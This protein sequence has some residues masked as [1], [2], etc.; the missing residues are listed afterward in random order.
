MKAV[1]LLCFVAAAIADPYYYTHN[2][3]YSSIYH[4]TTFSSHVYSPYSSI[5][6]HLYKRE[7]EAE[8]EAAHHVMPWWSHQK[9]N[10]FTPY[11]SSSI[12]YPHT[13][14]YSHLYK[15]EAEA[16]P[17]HHRDN[18]PVMPFWMHKKYNTYTPYMSSSIYHPYT[19]TYSHLYKREA[20]A[21]HHFNH[22]LYYSP[23]IYSPHHF[24][25]KPI[26][27]PMSYS[28]DAV[29]PFNYAAKGQYKAVTAGSMHIAKREAD[30]AYY[31]NSYP[32]TYSHY[33][34]GSYSYIPYN[35]YSHYLHY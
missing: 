8:P 18:L 15:R 28:N 33:N 4:P 14:T 35:T 11:V 26:M 5:Y 3:G 30:P 27:K 16:E 31:F 19:Y 17:V 20:D 22:G 25:Y 12:Y 9:Y 10:T 6:S 32:T 21:S 24:Q 13:Y 23:Y 7:A 2:L 34:L 1:L 29:K